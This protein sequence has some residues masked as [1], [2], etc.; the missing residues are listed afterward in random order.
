MV[1]KRIGRPTAS[2]TKSSDEPPPAVASAEVEELP[3]NIFTE[4]VDITKSK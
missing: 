2:S 4:P 1:R 3:E